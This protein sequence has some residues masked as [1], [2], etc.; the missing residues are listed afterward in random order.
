MI[1][2]HLS[3]GESDHGQWCTGARPQ[4]AWFRRSFMQRG[5]GISSETR[6]GRVANLIIIVAFPAVVPKLTNSELQR[7]KRR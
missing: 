6:T 2:G 7:G 5:Q 3:Q 1:A 4:C